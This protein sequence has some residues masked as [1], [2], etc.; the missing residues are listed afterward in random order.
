MRIKI[1]T[2]NGAEN[3][4][5]TRACEMNSREKKT[6]LWNSLCVWKDSM[7]LSADA[8]TSMY[9]ILWK[10][11]EMAVTVMVHL[12]VSLECA[13]LNSV[14]HTAF[15]FSR[16]GWKKIR[17]HVTIHGKFMCSFVESHWLFSPHEFDHAFHRNGTTNNRRSFIKWQE[18]K[19]S[20]I[21]GSF[22]IAP[23]L[24][25]INCNAMNS[26]LDI[27]IKQ[28]DFRTNCNKLKFTC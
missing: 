4:R 25:A 16:N 18:K 23:L 22:H 19:R 14:R 2:K 20:R 12:N 1:K 10:R 27:W 5:E 9:C 8:T 26:M 6:A 11:L 7:D 13:I 17:T 24:I 3:K 15:H 21:S 28:I